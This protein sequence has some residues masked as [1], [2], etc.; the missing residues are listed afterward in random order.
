MT[1]PERPRVLLV[2]AFERDNFGDLLFHLVT[3][4]MLESS[5]FAVDAA[6]VISAEVP[7]V[8]EYPVLRMHM[9]CAHGPMRPCGLWAV[10]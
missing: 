9:R 3:R 2:G 10:R 5:G 8:P 4:S 6:S 1:D 7:A